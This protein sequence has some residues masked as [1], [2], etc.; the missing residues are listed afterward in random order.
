MSDFLDKMREKI[1]VR[2]N[3]KLG[4]IVKENN[5]STPS[6]IE[7]VKKAYK[8]L[9]DAVQAYIE[10]GKEI[11]A[12]NESNPSQSNFADKGP[13]HFGKLAGDAE[14]NMV[15]LDMKGLITDDNVK[16]YV[17]SSYAQIIEAHEEYKR[18]KSLKFKGNETS[19]T[20]KLILD[21]YKKA[22]IRLVNVFRKWLEKGG[23]ANNNPK[24]SLENLMKLFENS[25]AGDFLEFMMENNGD[26]LDKSGIPLFD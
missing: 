24:T 19:E 13:S 4:R 15:D 20:D 5:T 14:I 18:V 12:T 22:G 2:E 9:S 16:S 1:Y 6:S 17:N 8:S 23:I 7:D 25:P 10:W 11:R 21:M 26:G 3:A